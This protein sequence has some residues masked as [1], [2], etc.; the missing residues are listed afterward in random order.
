MMVEISKVF[1]MI[2]KFSPKSAVQDKPKLIRRSDVPVTR[3][4]TALIKTSEIQ[5]VIL[6]NFYGKN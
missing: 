1:K 2:E 4:L 6:E 3:T 5:M